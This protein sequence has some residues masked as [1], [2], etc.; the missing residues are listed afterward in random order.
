MIGLIKTLLN[1][2]RNSFSFFS[3][4]FSA[5]SSAKGDPSIIKSLS[6]FPRCGAAQPTPLDPYMVS[7]MFSIS[8]F[9][10][11]FNSSIS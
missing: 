6:A 1:V 11:S 5:S 3:S 4:S 9:V 7:N 8:V 10:S 2:L